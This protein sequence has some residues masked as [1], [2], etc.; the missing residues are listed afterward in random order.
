M[1]SDFDV[2]ILPGT[3]DA[4]N[5]PVR[6]SPLA[7]ALAK[8][9][10]SQVILAAANFAVT[11]ILLRYASNDQ[12]G[13]YVLVSSGVLILTSLQGSL[14]GPAMVN[15]LAQLGLEGRAEL[16]GGLYAGQR[17]M[18]P[19]VFAFGAAFIVIL[20]FSHRLDSATSCLALVALMS[21]WTGL[22]RQ[23]FRMVSNAYR[24]ATASLCG[25]LAYAALL[26]GGA[27]IAITTPTPAIVTLIFM[28]LGSIGSGLVNSRLQWRTERWTIRASPQVWRG[29]VKV[30]IWP[31]A[32]TVA[33]WA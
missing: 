16:V 14:I 25:D 11:L 9:V 7:V 29:I 24:S 33:F 32:G 28:S 19:R 22:Y 20:W 23:F 4:V 10:I 31:A 18:L 27:L 5:P 2:Q 15:R 12:Y 8:G 21:G 17:R 30:G 3:G 6:R 13:C 1:P 26:L